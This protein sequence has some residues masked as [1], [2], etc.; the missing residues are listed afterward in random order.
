MLNL[1]WHVRTVAEDRLARRIGPVFRVEQRLESAKLLGFGRSGQRRRGSQAAADHLLH[2][3]EVAGPHK[4]LV[5]YRFVAE[6]SSP[7]ELFFLQPRI[8]SHPREFVAA[9]QLE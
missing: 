1:D 5:F 9:R 2:L 7:A 4:A 3:I 8:S 6:L